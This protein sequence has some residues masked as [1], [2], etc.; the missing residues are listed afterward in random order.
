MRNMTGEFVLV[1]KIKIGKGRVL[2]TSHK[3]V[4]HVKSFDEKEIVNG[5]KKI[6][7]TFFKQSHKDYIPGNLGGKAPSS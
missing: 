5:A 6:F 3:K 1:Y 7:R 2:K 4:Y